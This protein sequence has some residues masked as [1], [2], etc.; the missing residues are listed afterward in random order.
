M[1][2]FL[3]ILFFFYMFC[4]QCEYVMRVKHLVGN[5]CHVLLFLVYRKTKK[6]KNFLAMTR[7]LLIFSSYYSMICKCCN[8]FIYMDVLIRFCHF[9]HFLEAFLSEG[10]IHRVGAPKNKND[11]EK[12]FHQMWKKI[13]AANHDE[14]ETRNPISGIISF[15]LWLTEWFEWFKFQGFT[16]CIQSTGIGEIHFHPYK[17]PIRLE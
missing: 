3:Q 8:T 15:D 6:K 7:I 11:D 1:K 16:V 4:T 17:H 2:A 5:F 9:F 12:S 14:T 13:S 10:K